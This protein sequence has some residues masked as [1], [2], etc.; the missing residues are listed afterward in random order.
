[1]I[2]VIYAAIITSALAI[3]A[4]HAEPARQT[5]WPTSCLGEFNK[6]KG[7]I[8]ESQDVCRF[9]PSDAAAILQVCG[10]ARCKVTGM[11]IS[12]PRTHDGPD[13]EL[14]DVMLTHINFYQTSLA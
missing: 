3:C 1:M 11:A 14:S 7:W 5:P 6:S 2:N 8:R 12:I 4:A 9:K 10:K 13:L